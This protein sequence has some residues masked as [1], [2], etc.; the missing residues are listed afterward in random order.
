MSGY[1]DGALEEWAEIMHN[2]IEITDL[3]EGWFVKH[4]NCCMGGEILGW[5]LNKVT[6]NQKKARSY[7]QKMLDT[8]IIANVTGKTTFAVNDIY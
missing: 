3:S 4:T 7:C 2:E 5:L 1:V 6:S 8:K